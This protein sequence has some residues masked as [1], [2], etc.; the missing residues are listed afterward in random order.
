MVDVME[1]KMARVLERVQQVLDTNRAP[2]LPSKAA[3]T[4]QDKF[5]MVERAGNSGLGALQYLL[6]VLGLDQ[7]K[8]DLLQEWSKSGSAITLQFEADFKCHFLRTTESQEESPQKQVIEGFQEEAIVS[9]VVTTITEHFWHVAHGYRLVIIRGDQVADAILLQEREGTMEV[10]T[11]GKIKQQPH[12]S[13]YNFSPVSVLITNLIRSISGTQ[14]N[15]RVDRS[16]ATCYTPF[17]NDDVEQLLQAFSNLGQWAQEVRFHLEKYAFSI[18]NQHMAN[19]LN[20]THSSLGINVVVPVFPLMKSEQGGELLDEEDANKLLEAHNSDLLA[21]LRRIGMHLPAADSANAQLF[22]ANE[23]YL[24]ALLSHLRT[25]EY[26]LYSS[27]SSVESMLREQLIQAIGKELSVVDIDEFMRFHYPKI[28]SKDKVKPFCRDVKR[29]GFSPEGTLSLE[30]CFAGSN[31]GSTPVLTFFK[32]HKA[33]EARAMHFALSA[34]A[35]VHLE[36]AQFS[37]GL[38]LPRFSLN[39]I[40]RL[41]LIARARQFSSFVLLVGQVTS[42]DTMDPKHA[43]IV[44]NKDQV[45]LPV[46]LDPLP[47]SKAFRD[48]IESLSPEQQEFAKAFREMQLGSTAFAVAVIEIKPQL[49]LLLKLPP[50]SLTKEIKLTQDL[51]KLFIEFQVPSD[52]VTYDGPGS[53]PDVEKVAAVQKHVSA[54]LDMVKAEREEELELEKQRA[55]ESGAASVKPFWEAGD[56]SHSKSVFG[57]SSHAKSGFGTSS[58]SLETAQCRG[59]GGGGSPGDHPNLTSPRAQFGSSASNQVQRDSNNTNALNSQASPV[60]INE[61]SF[62]SRGQDESEIGRVSGYTSVPKKLD[63]AFQAGPHAASCLLTKLSVEEA[64]ELQRYKSLLAQKPKTSLLG[65]TAL[66]QSRS[67]A[68]DLLDALSR[69]GE[70]AL[71]QSQLHVFYATTLSFD[72]MV[73]D[74]LIQKNANPIKVMEDTARRILAA[75]ES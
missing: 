43:I 55:I 48:A 11:V 23:G 71:V 41:D 72:Q 65:A 31:N 12:P 62:E 21:E 54:L 58:I 38:L 7:A 22:T 45:M 36:G 1:E 67:K 2:V 75:I 52:L 44:Q 34:S 46:I 39:A 5:L 29:S 70:L 57:N 73:L 50:G 13:H 6:G 10:K 69:S 51:A 68:M 56:S 47:S 3:H 35:T 63:A 53:A 64:G 24:V 18:E 30:A 61:I 26:D 16:K 28:F 74:L 32:E 27:V 20:T 17:R 33:E 40:G 9:K 14:T 19:G 37:H 49:E 66:K 25:I 60:K 42:D 8:T 59:G 15:F 4:Y